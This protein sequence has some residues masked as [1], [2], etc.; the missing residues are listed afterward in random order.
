VL[1]SCVDGTP[2]TRVKESGPIFM[3]IVELVDNLYEVFADRIGA[4]L[5]ESARDLPRAL[6]LAPA[7]L[8]WS[9]VFPDEVTLGAPALFAESLH[10]VPRALLHDAVCAQMFA[11]IDAH[12]TARIEDERIE[13]SPHVFAVLGHVRSERDRAMLRLFSRT[14]L[15]ETD[16]RAADATTIRALRSERAA[17]GAGHPVGQ[18]VYERTIVDKRCAAILPSLA[19][20]RIAGADPRACRAVRATLESIAKAQQIHDDVVQW[21]ADVERGGAWA[22][23]LMRGSIAPRYSGKHAKRGPSVNAELLDSGV[24]EQMLARA[25]LHM[26]TARRRAGA[27]GA[28]RLASWATEREAHLSRLFTIEA[29]SAGAA[30]HAHSHA[31]GQRP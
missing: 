27:L 18:D 23:C 4:P 11:V 31:G 28:A 24:L 9:R 25:H 20:A 8:P 2:R 30:A 17:L 14:P 7:A 13:A 1:A 5:S 15:A 21:E 19:L 12:G 6:R 3:K 26:R 22:I 29:D 10:G 16:F